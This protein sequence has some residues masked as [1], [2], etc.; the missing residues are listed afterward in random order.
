MKSVQDP[1]CDPNTGEIIL[2]MLP[3][4][5]ISDKPTNLAGYGLSK[6]VDERI[7]NV[8]YNKQQIDDKI[9]NVQAGDVNLAN[10]Y[11]K[12]E[13]DAKFADFSPTTSTEID[14]EELN[15]MLAEI[16]I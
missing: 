11:T 3:W 8:T 16:L 2:D 13:I 14:E 12:N 1:I 5:R 6:E 15:A 7:A 10:Y 4:D 9:S